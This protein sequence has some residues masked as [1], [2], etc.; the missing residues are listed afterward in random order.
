MKQCVILKWMSAVF[1][2]KDYC[3]D[4]KQTKKIFVWK[5]CVLKSDVWLP[6][7]KEKGCDEFVLCQCC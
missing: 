5:L 6:I 1:T 2:F 7:F 4:K 3:T